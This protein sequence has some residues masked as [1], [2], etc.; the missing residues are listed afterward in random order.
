[1]EWLYMQTKP[2]NGG[3]P[4]KK[5]TTTIDLSDPIV[6]DR[7]TDMAHVGQLIQLARRKRPHPTCL[8]P[9]PSA[10]SAYGGCPYQKNCNLTVGQILQGDYMEEH[11]LVFG[12]LE[13]ALGI[14]DYR[15]AG[16]LGLNEVEDP[17]P[18]NPPEAPSLADPLPQI[19]EPAPAIV[20][21][22]GGGPEEL[23]RADLR[24][25]CVQIGV[26]GVDTKCRYGK[27][28]LLK[29]LR[30]F[31]AEDPALQE[32]SQETTHST[33]ALEIVLEHLEIIQAQLDRLRAEI[34][35]ALS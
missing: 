27:P 7:I 28:R 15:P 5:V 20:T 19:P 2:Q 22:P 8:P 31:K 14:N 6:E 30:A 25:Y 4:R 34:D 3:Y 18:V 33:V 23:E 32:S 12:A 35:N 1:L 11:D 29:M 9:V 16:P 21:V 24:D 10:C 26:P 13:K 17:D